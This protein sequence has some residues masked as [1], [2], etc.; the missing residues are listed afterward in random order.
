MSP[1]LPESDSRAMVR[2]MGDVAAM[3]G[4]HA[5]KKR[6]LMDGL[7]E[8]IKAEAWAWSL[9]CA[10]EP[11]APQTYVGV[12]HGGF[13]E[14]RLARFLLAVEHP[15]MGPPV[16][17]FNQRLKSARGLV[18]MQRFEIDPDNL[19]ASPELD[20]LWRAANI[21]PLIMAGLRIDANAA[22]CL[23]IY[24]P[25]GAADFSERAMQMVHIVL[26]EVPWLHLSGW[27]EDRGALVPKLAPRLRTVLNLLLDGRSRKEIAVAI[28]LS[29]HTVSGYVKEI[30]SHFSVSSQ[31]ELMRKYMHGL[32]R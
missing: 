15:Q 20:A 25:L 4:E 23:G 32:S 24:R 27:P 30:Y 3:E 2:L 13:S 9:S 8:L 5:E 11:A 7:C 10:I 26:S 29:T 12:L 18:V 6:Y 31:P 1:V 17:R 16:A 19:A 21:G 28:G 14:E 22:S